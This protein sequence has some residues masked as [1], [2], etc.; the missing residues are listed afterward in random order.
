MS[1]GGRAGGR[2]RGR[3]KANKEV[4][5][6]FD[7]LIGEQV[8]PVRGAM[9]RFMKRRHAEF[10]TCSQLASPRTPSTANSAGSL[11]LSSST[12]DLATPSLSS[13]VPSP[14]VMEAPSEIPSSQPRREGDDEDFFSELD[15]MDA[16]AVQSGKAEATLTA[17]AAVAFPAETL[18]D[19]A[20]PGVRAKIPADQNYV[21]ELT[22]AMESGTIGANGMLGTR[23]RRFMDS[24]AK[25]KADYDGIKGAN[26]TRLKAEFRQ[27]WAGTELKAK[28]IEKVES[29]VFSEVFSE[30][31]KYIPLERVIYYEG[32]IQF[33]SSVKAAMN[34]A[35]NALRMGKDMLRYNTMTERTDLFYVQVG[36]RDEFTRAFARHKKS[37]DTVAEPAAKKK[38]VGETTEEEKEENKDEVSAPKAGKAKAKAKAKG[39]AEVKQKLEVKDPAKSAM[40]GALSL[41]KGYHEVMGSLTNLLHNIENVA[42]WSWAKGTDVAP[43]Q[44]EV[45]AKL[46]R[47]KLQR[48]LSAFGKDFISLDLA[49]IKKKYSSNTL[50]SEQEAFVKVMTPVIQAATNEIKKLTGIHLLVTGGDG[51]GKH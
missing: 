11:G 19:D 18:D 17:A 23:F 43:N 26:S 2:G 50:P 48:E 31:G 30:F 25:D 7:R 36:K 29:E 32:G 8:Q 13:P 51:T 28:T 47:D 3:G 12:I 33:A 42:A 14:T 41:R 34:Y 24:N 20:G 6:D 5:D 40:V 46:M 38:R 35:K 44:H 16:S 37:V 49:T 9:D 22:K 45:G 10:E 27:R 4:R 15:R 1:L 21:E 39:T